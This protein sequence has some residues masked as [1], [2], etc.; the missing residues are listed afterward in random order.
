MLVQ[1]GRGVSVWCVA[2][3]SVEICTGFSDVM[4]LVCAKLQA[5][6]RRQE[7]LSTMLQARRRSPAIDR[8]VIYS[9]ARPRPRS[10]A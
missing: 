2:G 10:P 4:C 5:A 3:Q 7:V 9:D 6:S 1:R 8:F